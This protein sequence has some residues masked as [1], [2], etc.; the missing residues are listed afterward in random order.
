MGAELQEI[1]ANKIR[2][3]SWFPKKI[4]LR[5]S[6]VGPAIA[7]IGV[8]I[9]VA[10]FV[11]LALHEPVFAAIIAGLAV[12]I[13]AV[14]LASPRAGS[15]IDTF[16]ARLGYGIG[17]AVSWLLLAPIFL[18][19]FTLIRGWLW[20]TRADPL[21]LSRRDAPT[22]WLAADAPARKRRFAGAMFASERLTARRGMGLAAI[23][24]LVI[25]MALIAE[26]T[27]RVFGFGSPVLYR[28]D[29][30]AMFYP[31]PN[32]KIDRYGG[33]IEI[34][35]FGMRAP[36]YPTTKAAGTFRVLMIGDSTLYGGSYID[37]S[38]LYS[39]KL[40][41]RLQDAAPGR[42]VEVLAIGV[43]AWGPLQEL[44][45]I[46]RFGTFDADLVMVN[47]PIGDIYRPI[48]G[49][50][51]VPFFRADNPPRL[52][53]VEMT[54][55]LAWRIRANMEGAQSAEEKAWHSRRGIEAYVELA[56]LASAGGKPVLFEVLP[57]QPAGTTGRSSADDSKDVERLRHALG[58]L[59]PFGYPEGLFA[60]ASVP[61]YHDVCHLNA[62]GHAAY[63]PYLA[64]RI[65][66]TAAWR[67]FQR[68]PRQ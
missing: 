42:K 16:F 57:S 54:G 50:G 20:L 52:A 21:Q 4:A 8:G 5:H 48:F 33:R 55:H 56:R 62:A 53:L 18:V 68:G 37:Q 30:Q 35:R 45:Y 14:S 24:T 34:N 22:Y 36:D 44:G 66:H 27:L 38:E 11:A 7:K 64:E 65:M 10:G 47:L 19:G 15:L 28:T 39:R 58:T 12:T 49:L 63:T 3:I 61:V 23:A 41:K 9:G 6:R 32:Q 51:E 43:N 59:A 1:T 13:G 67:A 17:T 60:G 31:A 40:E 46:R 26:G 29:P 25:A 2:T